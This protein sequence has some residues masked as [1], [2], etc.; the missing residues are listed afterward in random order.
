MHDG[1]SSVLRT[2]REELRKTLPNT[3]M[4][5]DCKPLVKRARC[6]LLPASSNF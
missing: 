1:R 6:K 4:G 2:L 5:N 3:C